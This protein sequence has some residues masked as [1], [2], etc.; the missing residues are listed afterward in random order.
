MSGARTPLPLRGFLRPENW[1]LALAC[2]IGWMISFVPFRSLGALARPFAALLWLIPK[3]RRVTRANLAVCFPQMPEAEREALARR[4][5]DELALSLLHSIKIYFGYRPDAAQFQRVRFAGAEHFEAAVASERGII[6][7][8]CHYGSPDTNGVFVAQ[9]P[10]GSRRFSAVYRQPDEEMADAV[11]RW[12]RT[13]CIDA[14]IP[15]WDIRTM[16]KEL[17][18]GGMVWFAPDI[19]ASGKGTVFADFFGVPASTGNGLARIAA[20]SNAVVL[21]VRHRA[22]PEGGHVFEVFPPLEG[23]PTGDAV[24][25]ATRMNRAIAAMIADD[26]APYWWVIKRFRHRPPG[27]PPVY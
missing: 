21:P 23:F 1:K 27:L 26:P 24:A 22:A 3:L 9:L 20:M 8:S 14:L 25:D 2:G 10:R 7:L 5:T 15:S 19:E 4:A 11:I 6:L 13:K 18:A 12:G 17:R 16:L